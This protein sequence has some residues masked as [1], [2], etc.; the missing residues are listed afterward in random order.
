MKRGVAAAAAVSV[1]A[2]LVP[3]SQPAAQQT[4]SISADPRAVPGEGTHTFTIAGSGWTP[5]ASIFV[6]P[7][8]VPGEQLTT[9]HSP[10]AI[11]ASLSVMTVDDCTLRPIGGP[12]TVGGDGT[13]A[14]DLTHDIA[15]N[16]AFGA[17][18]AAGTE[19]SFAPILFTAA[20]GEAA[21]THRDGFSDVTGGVYKPAIDALART[22]LFDGS[23]CGED[24][25]CPD[26]PIDR[27]TMAVWL[28]RALRRQRNTPYR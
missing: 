28:I 5:G 16:F 3:T 2:M 26:E 27:S 21:Q 11:E 22:G 8:T 9:A 13:F 15:A 18:D 4:P 12:A 24:M 25:F 14:V 7:C 23:L 20:D 1:L 10:E 19:R 17:G 6:V